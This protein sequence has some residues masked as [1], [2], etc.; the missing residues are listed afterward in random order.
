MTQLPTSAWLPSKTGSGWNACSMDAPTRANVTAGSDF[1]Q[2]AKGSPGSYVV[3]AD[4]VACKADALSLIHG[5]PKQFAQ[6][7]RKGQ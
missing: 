3:V 1:V 2:E 5:V 6:A 7:L 4:P